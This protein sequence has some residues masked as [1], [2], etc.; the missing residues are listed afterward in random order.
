MTLGVNDPASDASCVCSLLT[1]DFAAAAVLIT[2]G[3]LLGKT[4]PL[5]MIV[6]AFFEIIFFSVNEYIG[7]NYIKVRPMWIC[8]KGMTRRTL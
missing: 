2:F 6:I 1:A 3:A 7:L 8:P 5:Q 4:S